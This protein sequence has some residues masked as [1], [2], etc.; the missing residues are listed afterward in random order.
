MSSTEESGDPRVSGMTPKFDGL[1]ADDP[2]ERTTEALLREVQWLSKLFASELEG[3][4][5][6]FAAMAEAI[7]LLQASADKSPT[8]GELNSKVEQQLNSIRLQF[9][10]RDVRT[11]LAA[12]GTKLAVDAAFSAQKEAAGEANKNFTKLIDQ[13]TLLLQA[14]SKGTDD[15]FTQRDAAL[16]ARDKAI[17]DK[18]AASNQ[19]TATLLND[20]KERITR[21]ESKGV[22]QASMIAFAVTALAGLAS[23]VAVVSAFRH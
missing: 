4:D 5:I 8:I 2:T 15:K 13:I 21:V 18:I 11:K 19:A 9:E 23:I 1:S 22:G 12:D 17:D 7:R 16:A 3:K 20:V 6:R 14:S 10:E